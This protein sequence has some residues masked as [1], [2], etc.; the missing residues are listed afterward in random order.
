MINHHHYYCLAIKPHRIIIGSL[1][2]LLL[3][4]HSCSFFLIYQA[5]MLELG[6]HQ[7]F[8]DGEIGE[9][10]LQTFRILSFLCISSHASTCV[11]LPLAAIEQLLYP[12]QSRPLNPVWSVVSPD[13]T[14]PL[15]RSGRDNELEMSVCLADG[16]SVC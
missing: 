16:L 1:N 10:S 7:S 13:Q 6:R 12:S 3:L 4:S 14:E 5:I 8:S 2:L 15:C 11:Y 9:I